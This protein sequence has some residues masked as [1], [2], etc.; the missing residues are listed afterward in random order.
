MYDL[1]NLIPVSS[2]AHKE[3]HQRYKDENLEDVQKELKS[4]CTSYLFE[5]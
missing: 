4:Y 3:I 2:E 1:E 5:G